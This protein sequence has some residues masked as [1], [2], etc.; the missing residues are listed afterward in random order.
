[1][2]DFRTRPEAGQNIPTKLY[3]CREIMAGHLKQSLPILMDEVDDVL[4]DIAIKTTNSQERTKYFN[5]MH[6]LRQKRDHIE[7]KFIEKFSELFSHN[8]RQNI[9]QNNAA[10]EKSEEPQGIDDLAMAN[11]V[12]KIR[13]NCY[14]ALLKLDE[15]MSKVLKANDLDASRNLVSPEVVCEAFN[16]ACELIDSETEIR[17]IIFKYFE[18]NVAG[19][20]NDAYSE[21]DDNFEI[22]SLT[23]DSDIGNQQTSTENNT[24]KDY[25]KIADVKQ[26]VTS[27]IQ[28]LLEDKQVPDFV[29]DF[30]FNN[31]AKLLTKIHNKNGTNSD[32]W[33]HAIETVEDLV[34][35]VGNIS[36]KE[37]RD[38]FDKL[39]P[40]LLIR[41]RNGINMISMSRH[42]ETDFISKL[43]KHRAALTMLGAL[44]KSKSNNV[45]IVRPEKIKALK[46]KI[47]SAVVQPV[48]KGMGLD[49][50]LSENGTMP[51]L[52]TYASRAQ[53]MD[54]QLVLSD[55]KKIDFDS[56]GTEDITIPIL[57]TKACKRPFMDE[58]LIDNHD[59][60]GFKF[61]TDEN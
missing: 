9:H 6:E 46:M 35:C 3:E 15:R 2:N 21:I 23:R 57:D 12:N 14:Q 17:L 33:Q 8:L 7:R 22:G 48:D 40:D 10:K 38:K 13:S 39:W 28:G 19:F 20:L 51:S 36:T 52:R 27:E 59:V 30:L 58:L 26:V 54:K 5:S 18:K 29:S 31:W 56:I 53:S 11:A 4:L 24:T 44:T 61:D 50:T 60:E 45:T 49:S 34:W 37:E 55:G 43:S 32:S 42:E 47:K 16:Y 1:M 41:L 25:Q